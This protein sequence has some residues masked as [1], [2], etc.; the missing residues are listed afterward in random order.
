MKFSYHMILGTCLGSKG[1]CLRLSGGSQSAIQNNC[2]G[3]DLLF[4]MIH[5]GPN[6]YYSKI[7]IKSKATSYLA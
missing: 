5:H 7:N 1:R 4:E 2:E 6:I 3:I